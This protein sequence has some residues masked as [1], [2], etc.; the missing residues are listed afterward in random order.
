MSLPIDYSDRVYAGVLGKIIGVYLGR[1][2]EQWSFERIQER[3]GDIE[4]YVHEKLGHPLIVADDD[5]TGTF[6]FIRALEDNDF[7]PNLSAEQIGRTWLNYIIENRTILWWGGLGHSTENTAFLRLKSGI[8]APESGSIARNGAT[9]AEQIGAQIFIDG[10][11][12]I[13]PNDPDR[14]ARF[15]REAGSVSHD[16]ASVDAAVAWAAME[17]AA[18][19][20]SNIDSLIAIGTSYLPANGIIAQVYRDV[21]A[22]FDEGLDWKTGFHRIDDKY[23]YAK[24][25]GGCHIVPNH[26]LM[27]HALLHGGG[28]F[29][30]SMIVV[31]SCGWDTDCNAANIGCLLG[32]RG[33][34]A[35]IDDGPDWRGPVA[36][37]MILPTADGGR[38]VSNA[39]TE[40]K[41][42]IAMGRRMQG[43]D[44]GDPGPRFDFGSPGAVQGFAVDDAIDSR[45]TLAIENE[46]ADGLRLKYRKL[47]TGRRARVV[48]PTY[49]DDRTLQGG[50]YGVMACPTLYAGQTVRARIDW[51]S[52]PEVHVRLVARFDDSWHA[53]PL[54]LVHESGADLTW[55]LPETQGNPIREVGVE[56]MSD[57]PA[58]G[59]LALRWLDWD[60]TPV[61]PISAADSKFREKTWINAADELQFWG[62]PMR[63]VAN[64]GPG[65]AIHGAAEW[66]G[67]GISALVES[68]LVGSMGVSVNVVGLHRRIDLTL[69]SAG[70]SL[71][72]YGGR[73]VS[74]DKVKFEAGHRFEFALA[75]EGDSVVGAVDGV[76]LRLDNVRFTHGAVACHATEGTAKFQ[77]LRF[78]SR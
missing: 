56:I 25:G 78:Y 47:A 28:D 55:T 75:P 67:V 4:Y 5:I 39:W 9:V 42:I 40:A 18:F 30:R 36:D 32:I 13:F 14:A 68:N 41:R 48:T 58:S 53:G 35:A 43:L 77:G 2:F 51:I 62:E 63:V 54:T 21:R 74:T 64:R 22:W 31:N 70:L 72:E 76:E 10:W 20:E 26:A 46:A 69:D 71:S 52:G 33:G 1:P 66:T 50:G 11:P 44:S 45:G 61:G 73:S 19:T 8:P 15:A 29:H 57:V 65:S 17:S 12:M 27:I 7:D 49:V 34:L 16:G 23:G 37:R 60:G 59:E 3:F 24:Y 6:T 38:C